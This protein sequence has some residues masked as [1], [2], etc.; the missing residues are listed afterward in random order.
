MELDGANGLLILIRHLQSPHEKCHP[1]FRRWYFELAVDLKGRRFYPAHL[2]I[3]GQLKKLLR[4][5]RKVD[6][7]VIFHV[8]DSH[9]L[10]NM[11]CI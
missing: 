5:P 11:E 7:A 1:Q 3:S 8:F 4:C 6:Q 9:T 10:T 2:S